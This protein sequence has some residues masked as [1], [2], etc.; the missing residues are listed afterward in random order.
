M[1]LFSSLIHESGHLILMC[2][3]G[4]R[5]HY[6]ELSLFGMRIEKQ[7]TLL[8]Y[9]KEALIAMGGIILNFLSAFLG[10]VMYLIFTREDFLF[11]SA[12]NGF[13]ALVNMIPVKILDFG[14]FIQCFLSQRYDE[15]KS[16]RVLDILSAL[17]TVLL[18]LACVLYCVFI[19]LN[20]SFIA[21]TV[22]LNV[23]TFK[24]KWS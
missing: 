20:I 15:E 16:E 1:S 3:F 5:I 4:D 12:V 18:S 10:F 21:V 9:K 13:I 17:C 22:Y 8:S 24:K 19:R 11:F 2:L 7:S 14:R 23:I 6:V